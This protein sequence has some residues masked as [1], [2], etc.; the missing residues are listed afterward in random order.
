[1]AARAGEAGKGFAV[2]ASEVKD[3]AKDTAKATEDIGRK[4]EAIQADTTEA[5]RAIGEISS[6]IARINDLQSSIASAVEEQSV[7]TNEIGNSVSE[8]AH[9]AG[10]IASSVTAVAQS[11]HATTQGASDTQAAASELARMADDLERL[12][13]RFRVTRDDDTVQQPRR[14]ARFG[15]ESPVHEPSAAERMAGAWSAR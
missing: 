9:G 15:G 12:V 2:V 3:L 1:E 6:I 4:I 5:V 11:A 13:G 10:E 7:T 14:S 8:A